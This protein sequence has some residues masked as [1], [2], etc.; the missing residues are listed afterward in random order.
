MVRVQRGP[1]VRV[2]AGAMAFISASCHDGLGSALTAG[3]LEP[4]SFTD[5][6]LPCD[7]LIPSAFV[8]V[9][10][11]VLQVPVVNVGDQDRWLQPK[12]VLGEL[13]F[14]Q[15]LSTPG[16][17]QVNRDDQCHIA[18]VCSVHVE[19]NSNIDFSQL[20]WPSLSAQEQGE[21]QALLKRH[22]SIFSEFDG[23]L[24]CTTLV[25][26]TIPVLDSVPVRQRYRRLPPSQYDLVKAH[27]QELVEH[28]VVRPSSSPYASPIVVVQKKDGSIRL[29][30]DYRQLNAKTRKDAFPL[31]RI[32]ESLDALSGAKWFSTLDLA[33][34][35]N[36]VPVLEAD[37]EKNSFL[38]AFWSV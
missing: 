12:T 16:V 9:G 28:Q 31:P 3:L 1:A 38:Y 27:I 15:S 33:S 7:L 13:H 32:E 10:R 14:V 4:V 2:P 24:G 23:D 18:T 35:Y 19:N 36:Q 34:G 22:Q 29:C 5:G 17:V 30:V 6:Q 11:G 21:A 20:T 25:Q 8:S 37:K 26:H